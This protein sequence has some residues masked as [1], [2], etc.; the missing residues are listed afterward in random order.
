MSDIEIKRIDN[1]WVVSWYTD[2]ARHEV[3]AASVEQLQAA[4]AA[5]ARD[6]DDYLA[7]RRASGRK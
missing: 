5:G 1:G 7:R 6:K 4:V 2:E 3:F